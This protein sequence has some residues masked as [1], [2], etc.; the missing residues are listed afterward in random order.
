MF[1]DTKIAEEVTSS[2]KH[3]NILAEKT[4]IAD[5]Y[6]YALSFLV[7]HISDAKERSENTS[8]F[9]VANLARLYREKF[10]ERG[11]E[12]TDN[13][14]NSIKPDIENYYWIVCFLIHLKHLV[15]NVLN[16][17]RGNFNFRLLFYEHY[18]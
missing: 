3:K 15:L 17:L 1:G 16:K 4:K 7:F 11:I 18:G 8:A 10:L 12:R 14:V 5:A 2:I 9:L 6:S 13:D